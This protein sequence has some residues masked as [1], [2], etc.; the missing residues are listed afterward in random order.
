M[1]QKNDDPVSHQTLSD[2]IEPLERRPRRPVALSIA[3]F[4]PSSGAG[5]TADLKVFAA[6]GI[7]GMSAITGLTVQSTQ[8]V[9]DIL[10]VDPEFLQKTLECLVED[11]NFDGIK[12]GMLSSSQ[13]LKI[14]KGFLEKFAFRHVV[15]DP[16]L[17]ATSGALLSGQED[18]KFLRETLLP[19]ITW[20]TPNLAELSALTGESVVKRADIPSA[21]RWL[22]S[23]AGGRGLNV[24]V[25]GGHLPVPEDYLLTAENEEVWIRG[26]RIKTAST[27]G[28]GCTFSSSLLCQ[29]IKGLLPQEATEAAK[30]YVTRALQT[31][32]PVGK[33]HGPLN[34]FFTLDEAEDGRH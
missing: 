27:H 5:V 10:P 1:T 26:E 28:T 30:H 3:G 15:L 19:Q 25:T 12:I 13:N 20:I 16:I 29:L 31:A 24:V 8:G 7:Y 23:Q 18:L 34:H 2:P 33:G 22:K 4:D 11:V 21:A 17:R 6:H 32:Y 14:I 9:R